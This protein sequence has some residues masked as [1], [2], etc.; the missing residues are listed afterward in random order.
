MRTTTT[1]METRSIELFWNVDER[2]ISFGLENAAEP[3]FRW[4]DQNAS[5]ANFA[6]IE[7][8]QFYLYEEKQFFIMKARGARSC[9]F[10]F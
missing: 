8:V 4:Q 10:T 3:I 7:Y 9:V 6:D 2:S 1:R 5:K